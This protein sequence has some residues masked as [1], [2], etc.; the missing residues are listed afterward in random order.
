MTDGLAP[1]IYDPATDCMYIKLREGAGFDSRVDDARDLI[2][3]LG[4]DGEPVGYDIQHA[5][6]HPDVVAEA[7]R[8][9]RRQVRQRATE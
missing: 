6:E 2:V 5:S 7:L 1:I 8:H 4:E 3:D 9:M